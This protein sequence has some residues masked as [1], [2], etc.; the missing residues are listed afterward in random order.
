MARSISLVLKP[1]SIGCFYDKEFIRNHF[2]LFTEYPIPNREVDVKKLKNYLS[3]RRIPT[4]N[5]DLNS[6]AQKI[7]KEITRKKLEKTETRDLT[8]EELEEVP[9]I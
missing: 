2:S 5:S 9:I 1:I 4:E 8:Q 3:E 6:L 7:E